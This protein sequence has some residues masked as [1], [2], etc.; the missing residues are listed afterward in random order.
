M[1][2]TQAQL[3]EPG[4]TL[5]EYELLERLGKGGFSVVYRARH[6]KMRRDVALKALAPVQ[7]L[8]DKTIAQRFLREIDLI[9]Q[10]E[11]PN[12]VRLYD[13]GE[14]DGLLWM[15]ME[16]VRGTE[17]ARLLAKERSLEPRRVYDLSLQI[18]AGLAEAHARQIVHRDLKPGNIMVGETVTGAELVK[19]LDFGIGKALGEV[20]EAVKQN[21]T[22]ESTGS[23]GTPRYMAPELLKNDDSVGPHSD[24]YAFGLILYEML[25][26]KPAVQGKNTYEVLT[27]QIAMGL[28]LPEWLEGTP[29]GAIIHTATQKS[30]NQRFPDA[31]AML[32]AFKSIPK[33]DLLTKVNSEKAATFSQTMKKLELGLQPELEDAFRDALSDALSFDTPLPS[34]GPETASNA[35]IDLLAS[36][37]TQEGVVEPPPEE[38]TE[39]ASVSLPE[40]VLPASERPAWLIPAAVGGGVL[41]LVILLV[42]V[43]SGGDADDNPTSAKTT[44]ET[45]A[46]ET[47]SPPTTPS[48]QTDVVP[49]PPPVVRAEAPTLAGRRDQRLKDNL[50]RYEAQKLLNAEAAKSSPKNNDPFSVKTD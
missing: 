10:L 8:E 21:L 39:E 25:T 49:T 7:A 11:H 14:S 24:V 4:T 1:S 16:L 47:P 46:S 27:R 19:L 43:F 45:T 35:K 17:L 3:P 22:Q 6:I 33:D 38:D 50:Q 18:L 13:F 29:F 34:T 26:G 30:Y 44:E 42:V 28:E 9:Q 41:L 5:G 12:I 48:E 37:E 31:L 32:E 40:P 23:V 15:A 36:P 20:D 2:I